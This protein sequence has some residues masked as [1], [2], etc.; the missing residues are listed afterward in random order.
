MLHRVFS[1]LSQLFFFWSE[2]S[3]CSHLLWR[4]H[5]ISSFYPLS[6][7]SFCSSSTLLRASMRQL[8]DGFI[9]PLIMISVLFP[10][11]SVIIPVISLA[12]L[13]I[14]L[15]PG[16]EL[17][18]LWNYFITEELRYCIKWWSVTWLCQWTVGLL[19]R[20]APLTN[21]FG[22][23]RDFK[24]GS[25]RTCDFMLDVWKSLTL[26]TMVCLSL[27]WDA[28]VNTSELKR[29]YPLTCKDWQYLD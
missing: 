1:T 23:R 29:V 2:N 8:P 28:V 15:T 20:R 27:S 13:T 7:C 3:R 17:K 14:C 9:Q 11:Y 12:F 25:W 22:G 24:Q 26:T 4:Y 5:S 6:A 18:L 10:I 19:G 21:P 16:C